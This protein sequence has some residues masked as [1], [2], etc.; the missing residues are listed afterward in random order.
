MIHE[1][2]SFGNILLEDRDDHRVLHEDGK[3]FI[4][5]F[6]PKRIKDLGVLALADRVNIG[7]VRILH[8]DIRLSGVESL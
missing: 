8:R 2:F 6:A 7:G 3:V 5:R 4:D 1:K